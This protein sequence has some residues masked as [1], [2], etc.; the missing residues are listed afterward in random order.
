MK[1][2]GFRLKLGEM[3]KS[4]MSLS[5]QIQL[6]FHGIFIMLVFQLQRDGRKLI[7]H[8]ILFFPQVDFLESQLV[9]HQL[10]VLEL[11]RMVETI[12]QNWM[13]LR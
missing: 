7:S 11:W 2:E 13:Y 8:S 12:T 5:E 4:T 9:A 6:F 1:L 3:E 10:K